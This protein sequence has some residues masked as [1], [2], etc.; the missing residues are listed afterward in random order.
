MT[1]T[2]DRLSE[3]LGNEH[4]DQGIV[5]AKVDTTVNPGIQN[6]FDIQGYPTLQFI[7]GGKMYLYEGPR[8]LN[9]LMEFALGGYKKATT[10]QSVPPDI[11]AWKKWLDTSSQ[12]FHEN[13][14][15]RVTLKDFY[16]ILDY[17]KNA[18][19]VLFVL[20][21]LFGFILGYIMAYIST[22]CRSNKIKKD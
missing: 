9:D 3:K 13:E 19:L 6:R 15:V 10:V 12:K 21:S 14:F 2:W 8:T 4:A 16:H 18:A 20:G 5:I 11:S 7:A 22:A 17:R 1:P